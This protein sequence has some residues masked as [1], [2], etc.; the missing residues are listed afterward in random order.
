MEL[1]FWKSRWKKGQIGWHRDEV[2]PPLKHHLEHFSVERGDTVLVPLCGKSRDMAW[3]SEQGIQ[4]IGVEISKIAAEQFFEQE[5][6]NYTCRQEHKFTI[7]ESGGI[8]LWQGDFFDLDPDRLPSV[9]LV[10]DKAALIA[11]PPER[12]K[13]YAKLQKACCHSATELF[14]STFE[15]PEQEMS[16]PPFSIFK[17]ELERL[18]G[19]QFA[20]EL[21]HEESL[22]NKVDQIRRWGVSSFFREKSYRLKPN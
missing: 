17:E 11:L 14:I 4:V 5:Q 3:L 2:Y 6:K 16:G 15:Y 19:D 7:F 9:D 12:R 10:Y 21:L 18:Y 1:S 22:L 8:Q 13:P 20:I